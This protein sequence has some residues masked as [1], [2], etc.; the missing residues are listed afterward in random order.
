MGFQYMVAAMTFLEWWDTDES[1]NGIYP[2]I[3]AEQAW[4]HQQQQIDKLTQEVRRLTLWAESVE[5]AVQPIKS[6]DPREVKSG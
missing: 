3:F 5:K 2:S 6:H 1:R 4:K